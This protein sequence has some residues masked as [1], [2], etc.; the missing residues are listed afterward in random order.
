[1]QIYDVASLTLSLQDRAIPP[2]KKAVLIFLCR[3]E[4]FGKNQTYYDFP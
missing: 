3:P 2:W 1:M 4:T